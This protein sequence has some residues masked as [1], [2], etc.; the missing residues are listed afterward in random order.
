VTAIEASLNALEERIRRIAEGIEATHIGDELGDDALVALGLVKES[1]ELTEAGDDYYVARHVRQDSD[2]AADAL[3]V[4]MRR[5]PIATAFCAK[6]WGVGEIP[7]TGS[8][9]LLKRL[10]REGS[11][12][13]A[14]RWLELMN[15]GRLIAYNRKQPML[16]VGFNPDELVSPEEDAA[17]E[18]HKGHV[19]APDTPYGNLLSLREL[20]RA[21]RGFLYWYEQH[22]DKK[23][24]EVLYRELAKG[25]VSTVHL[26]SGP[27]HADADAKADYKRF[28][29]E[30]K[31][32]RDID[33]EWR[34]L[35]KKEA[36]LH[37][38]RFFFS[39]DIRRNLPPLNLI[40]QGSTGEILPSDLTVGDFEEWW[41]EGDD[42]RTF[43]LPAA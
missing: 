41:A 38:D 1:G 4:L 11:D 8:V 22:M 27:A 29:R 2:A 33:C 13:S 42:L 36:Q 28:T 17:R 6:L 30:M 14:K 24:L 35:S 39:E 23:V 34:I 10:T 26:L 37:H 15:R 21:S 5:S 3:G 32:R 40:L 19:V 9:S 18:R 43:S 20:L 16:R 12:N 7:V 31:A 25:T